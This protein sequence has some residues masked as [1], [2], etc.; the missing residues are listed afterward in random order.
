M[1]TAPEV[2]GAVEVE[3]APEW[4]TAADVET[5]V[6]GGPT[7]PEVFVGLGGKTVFVCFFFFNRVFFSFFFRKLFFPFNTRD[8][9]NKT[10]KKHFRRRLRRRCSS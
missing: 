6:Q 10:L 4:K 2:E 8:N 1:E 7:A 3:T 5:A 9:Q